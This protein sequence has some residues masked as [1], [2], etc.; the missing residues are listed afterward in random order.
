M[1]HFRCVPLVCPRRN[2]L[3][4]DRVRAH[5]RARC[6]SPN[7]RVAAGHGARRKQPTGLRRRAGR[8]QRPAES[9]PGRRVRMREDMRIARV[10]RRRLDTTLRRQS[11]DVDWTVPVA[12]PLF[13]KCSVPLASL[14]TCRSRASGP[15]AEPTMAVSTAHAPWCIPRSDICSTSSRTSRRRIAS[16]RSPLRS[17]RT[18]YRGCE[19]AMD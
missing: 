5:A 19:S 18:W 17:V 6:S 1:T 8:T 13:D 14:C 15:G 10:P 3:V 4:C 7:R 9:A 16:T 11:P 2:Y 12:T